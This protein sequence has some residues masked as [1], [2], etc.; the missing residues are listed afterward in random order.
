MVVIVIAAPAVERKNRERTVGPVSHLSTA[1]TMIH[2][3]L[4]IPSLGPQE[5]QRYYESQD[6]LQVFYYYR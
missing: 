2:F 5:L 6:I 4:P 3:L 1:Y